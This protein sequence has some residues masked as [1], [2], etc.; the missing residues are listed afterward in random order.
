MIGNNFADIE[1]AV[2]SWGIP[3]GLRVNDE[4][5]AVE[6]ISIEALK[7]FRCAFL[8]NPNGETVDALGSEIGQ[9]TPKV[10]PIVFL[11]NGTATTLAVLGPFALE[12]STVR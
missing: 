8:R 7:I 12:R 9:L 6:E 2:L 3:D 5:V 1:S 11:G 4:A 10:M